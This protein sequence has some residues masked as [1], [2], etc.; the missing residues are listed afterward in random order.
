MEVSS[1]ICFAGGPNFAVRLMKIL[2]GAK[3]ISRFSESRFVTHQN[4]KGF[5]IARLLL[6]AAI[7]LS[8][9]VLQAALTA[10]FNIAEAQDWPARTVKIV[11]PYGPGGISDTLARITADRLSTIFG[12]RFIVETH[13]GA[14]GAIGTEY[15]ARSPPDG[16]TLYFAGGAEF[17]VVPLMQKL[18]Y[19]PIKDLAPISMAA[20][21]GMALVVNRDLPVHTVG[22]FIEYVRANPGKINYGSVGHGSS[23]DLT[24]AAF[25]ARES[26]KLVD[27]PYTAT[28]PS[29]LAVISGSIQMFFGNVSDV[30]AAVRSGDVR[31]LAVS[32][33]KRLPQFPDTPTVSETVPGFVM[34]GWNGYFAPAGT[35]RPII[36][37][38]SQAIATI[39]HDPEIIKLM[40]NLSVDAMG[41]TPE[42]L[43]AAIQ[44]DL[45][46]YRDAVRAAG[47]GQ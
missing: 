11:V 19:D 40:G 47:L 26:L 29:I 30:V 8:A 38:L 28:P 17:S 18:S 39:C 24:P 3:M 13:P 31:L 34:T 37:R 25:A 23:S 35:P 45:P 43:A 4:K 44:A 22:E 5:G 1:T 41:G 33:A 32:T 7:V 6:R 42:E 27:V 2:S 14:S 20:I 15:A 46:I 10:G 9:A 16:Y 12:Q 36:D 21:N